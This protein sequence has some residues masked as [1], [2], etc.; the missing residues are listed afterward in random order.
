MSCQ[1]T[2]S[3]KSIRAHCG[4][5]ARTGYLTCVRHSSQEETIITTIAASA[6]KEAAFA[7]REEH[8]KA[9]GEKVLVCDGISSLQ[10]D[11]Y[12]IKEIFDV[13]NINGL[14]YYDD[15]YVLYGHREYHPIKQCYILYVSNTPDDAKY[16]AES[17]IRS[18]MYASALYP[19]ETDE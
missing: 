2:L 14:E 11:I 17:L 19:E 13:E 18:D 12:A 8:Q 6:A 1:G 3:R 9:I 10:K 5:K 7:Q 4:V 15:V 16:A